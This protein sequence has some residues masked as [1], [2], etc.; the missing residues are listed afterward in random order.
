M[1]NW[2]LE[3]DPMHSKVT[4][5]VGDSQNMYY[6]YN[7][8]NEKQKK[9]DITIIPELSNLMKLVESKNIFIMML[10][11]EDNIE[12]ETALQIYFN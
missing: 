1:K 10:L 8:I 3:P 7:F 5:L 6:L 9:W 2:V 11:I 4:L 12:A